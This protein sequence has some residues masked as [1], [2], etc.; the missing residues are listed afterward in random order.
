MSG[1]GYRHTRAML[2]ALAL[3]AGGASQAPAQTAANPF[4]GLWQLDRVK[5]QFDPGPPPE[6]RVTWFQV[7]GDSWTHVREQ[8]DGFGSTQQMK[9]TAK[10]DGKDY[11]VQG[12][13]LDTVSLK[14]VGE[15]TIERIG[16]VRGGPVETMTLTVS[17]DGNTL[18]IKAKGNMNERQYNNI[19]V[20]KRSL[21]SPPVR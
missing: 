3:V 10:F 19:E 2:A 7:A 13:A 20:Y 1:I 5:S 6:R 4:V 21:D 12:S 11:P 18:T 14:R 8:D 9:Y 16:K 15:R 17:A